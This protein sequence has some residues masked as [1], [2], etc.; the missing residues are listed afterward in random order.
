MHSVIIVDDN[1]IAVTAITQSTDWALCGCKVAGVAYDGLNGLKL[2]Q[3]EKPDIVMIDIQMPGFNG[4]DIIEKIRQQ[5]QVTRFIVISG[6]SDFSYAQRAIR[7][8]VSDFL[9]KP[10]MTEELEETLRKTVSSICQSETSVKKEELDDL[11]RTINSIRLEKSYYSSTISKAVD[12]V[13]KNIHRHISLN[14]ICKELLV[15]NSYFSKCFKKET[16]VGFSNYVTMVKMDNAR[17]LLK[18][19]QNRVNE[20]AHMLGYRDYAYFFQV[21]KKQ[22]GY[23]PSEIKSNRK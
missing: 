4:L 20:V 10:I 19:P 16:K 12:Y 18:N 1:K 11:L 17:T 7:Y 6:F 21:F 23:A 5:N 3:K 9:L 14:K 15:S 8:G 13:D 2:I 22:F